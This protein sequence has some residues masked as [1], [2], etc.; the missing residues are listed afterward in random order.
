M[1]C[2]RHRSVLIDV[3][4]GAPAPPALA[5]HLAE[6]EACRAALDTEQ[7]FVGRL[8]AEVEDSLHLQPSVS[9]LP[10]VR[11]RVT[12]PPP[13][14]RRW[15]V[16]WLVPATIGLL[17]V[18]RI[19]IRK[20]AD[21]TPAHAQ[22][23]AR[24]PRH[25][26]PP[27]TVSAPLSPRAARPVAVRVARPEPVCAAMPAVLIPAA[28]REALRRYMRD[29]QARRVDSTLLRMVGVEPGGLRSIEMPPIDLAPIRIAIIGVQPLTMDSPN[30]GV[31]E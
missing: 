8:D 18:S 4:L 3:A 31:N 5:V 17:L 26:P 25:L 24:E 27:R 28:E 21:P 19:L 23:P 30:L 12:E 29:L 7:Q 22:G 1:S 16:V 14:R 10:R 6:C 11:Q 15:L 13:A 2:E 9:F 20:P